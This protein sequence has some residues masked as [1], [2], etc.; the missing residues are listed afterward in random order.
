MLFKIN[1]ILNQN[2]NINNKNNNNQNNNEK[3]SKLLLNPNY[4]KNQSKYNEKLNK[5]DFNYDK[6][7]WCFYKLNNNLCDI[8]LE[9]I[10]KFTTEKEYKLKIIEYIR[11]N[12]NEF[13][14]YKI[15]KNY[16]EDDLINNKSISLY[17]FF[18][19][20]LIYKIKL[21]IIKKNIYS[22]YNIDSNSELLNENNNKL[23][24]IKFNYNDDKYNSF[25]IIDNYKLTNIEL[26]NIINNYFY[27]KNMNKPIMSMSYY[28]L[29][30]L[31][32]IANKLHLKIFNNNNKKKIKKELYEEIFNLLN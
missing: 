17:T 5:Y 27:I 32:N 9:Y 21:L 1:S 11:K 13:K 22:K 29:D 10:N 25:D 26:N 12:K 31:I 14:I 3:I 28:K 7:F 20:I 16:I 30:D 2:I 23:K 6:L 19:L 8:D 15:K 24:I 4:N 18:S